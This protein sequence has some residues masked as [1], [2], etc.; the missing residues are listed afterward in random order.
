MTD[1]AQK[2]ILLVDDDAF[3]RSM[4]AHK[5]E[6]RGFHVETAEAG[7]EALE[8]LRAGLQ[9]DVIAFDVIMPHLDGFGLLE[10]LGKEQLAPQAVKV[11]LTNEAAPEDVA[12]LQSLGV[13]G[14]VIKASSVPS[15]V[16][17]EVL[18]IADGNKAA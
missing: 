5:F 11:A 14:H 1:T 10:A 15:G 6:E 16:V 3:L 12:R 4:Y 9:P 18:R 7:D 8:K 17:T 13:T 2:T